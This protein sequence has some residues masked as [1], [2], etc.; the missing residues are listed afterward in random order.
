MA[1]LIRQQT[2]IDISSRIN[3]YDGRPLSAQYIVDDLLKG[4]L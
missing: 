3:K 4:V 1:T 2:G